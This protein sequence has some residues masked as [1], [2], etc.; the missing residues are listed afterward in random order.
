[1]YT[2]TMKMF[3]IIPLLSAF[4]VQVIKIIIDVYKHPN[5]KFKLSY[6]SDYGGM[7]SS[8][9][10]LFVSLALMSYLQ[11]G[12]ASFEFAV[13]L[14]LYLTIVRDAVG[15]RWH[16]GEHG[17]MLKQII[18]EEYKEHHANIQHERIVTRLGHTPA[19]ATV[20]TLC[21]IVLTL[22]FYWLFNS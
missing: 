3:L 10:A 4:I 21:G 6:F 18:Q 5:H 22:L 11:F 12:W 19:E 7:P 14:I 15:I 1:M 17:K 8:H 2:L 20:G 9:S 13:S 16:L